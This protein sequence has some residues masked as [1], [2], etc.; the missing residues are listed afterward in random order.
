MFTFFFSFLFRLTQISLGPHF[1]IINN[2]WESNRVNLKIFVF[3]QTGFKTVITILIQSQLDWTIFEPQFCKNYLSAAIEVLNRAG[4]SWPI[5]IF[6]T[7]LEP[8]KTGCSWK[9]PN[10]NPAL[11]ECFNCVY[12]NLHLLLLELLPE[13][14]LMGRLNPKL[15]RLSIPHNYAQL[16]QNFVNNIDE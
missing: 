8:H 15:V 7:Q 6:R 10:L 16:F 5:A 9:K 2:I 13:R 1:F 11:T 12:R 3:M 4:R 14:A